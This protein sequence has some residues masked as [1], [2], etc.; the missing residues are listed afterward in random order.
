MKFRNSAWLSNLLSCRIQVQECNILTQI[1]SLPY[2]FHTYQ[3]PGMQEPVL[4]KDTVFGFLSLFNPLTVYPSMYLSSR[5]HV[6]ICVWK[7]K[8]QSLNHVRPCDR[9][10]CSPPDSSI[11]EI[12]QTRILE[13]VAISFSRGSSWF[14]DR[15]QVSC[16]AGGLYCLSY[17]GS[18]YIKRIYTWKP[19]YRYRYR[20]PVAQMVKNLSAMWETWVRSLRWDNHPQ[21]GMTIHPSILAWRIPMDRGSWQA[22]VQGVPES[23]ARPSN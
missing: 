17:Q 1:F 14:R 13:S 5:Y 11:H 9:M 2:E 23:P 20:Y 10:D 6:Y 4:K 15:T 8:C 3:M 12:L 22:T 7:W 18:P 21:E 16:I 19:I